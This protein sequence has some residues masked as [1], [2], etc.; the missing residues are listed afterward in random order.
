MN[1]S[2]DDWRI[3]SALLDEALEVPATDRTAWFARRDDIPEHLLAT[4]RSMVDPEA[5]S[6]VLPELPAYSPSELG[7]LESHETPVLRQGESVGP[8]RL[9]REI[10]QG[11]MGTVWLAER[12]DE[13]L[14]REVALKLPHSTLT[15]PHLAERF[16]RERDILAALV[17]PNIARLYDAGITDQGQP[18]L[19]LEYVDGQSLTDYCSAS[20]RNISARIEL[21]LQVLLAVQYAH[22]RLVVHRDLKPSNVLVTVEG[23]IRLLDFGIAKLLVDGQAHETE[24]TEVGGRA[25]TPQYAAPEQIL[26]LP[27]TTAVDVYA[28]GVM[29]YELLTGVLPYR[30]KRDSRGALEDAIVETEVLPPSRAIAPEQPHAADRKVLRGDLDT[31]VLKALKKEPT[32]RYATSAAFADDL[33][34]YLDGE[35]VLARP[36]STLYR[37]RKFLVRNRWAA[38]AV[39]LVMVALSAGLGVALW[40]AKI[41]RQESETAGAVKEFMQGIFLANSAQQGDPIKA[42]QTTA[43]DLLDIGAGKLDTALDKAPE[44]KLEMLQMFGELYSQLQLSER[45][46]EFMEK[47]VALSKVVHGPVSGELV[48]AQLQLAV[49]LRDVSPD[50]PQ[51]GKVLDVA[52]A[53]L[54]QRHETQ[55]ERR[56]IHS[57]LAADY[58]ADRDFPRA[59]DYARRAAALMRQTPDSGDFAIVLAKD[60]RI[61]LQAGNCDDA[62]TAAAEAITVAKKQEGTR[63]AGDGSNT[64]YGALHEALGLADRCLGDV[65]AGATHLQQ[66]LNASRAAFGDNDT[67][68]LSIQAHLADILLVNGRGAQAATELAQASALLDKHNPQDTSRLYLNALAALGKAQVRAGQFEPALANLTKVVSIRAGVDASVAVAEVLR[69]QARALVALHRVKEAKQ[70]LEQAVTMRAKSGLQSTK[71]D[72]EEAELRR[73]IG[74]N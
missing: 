50:H 20:Q 66:A 2:Q 71:L 73:E 30:P 60:A 45:A 13:A 51:I 54:D 58:Y 49:A 12:R 63:K 32:A 16:K 56:S 25:L 70:S 57:A 18:Y 3:L 36:D 24:L 74:S 44:A 35:P 23:H 38:A 59:V 43:R 26:G 41:A 68:T 61:E 69:D 15:K 5:K 14:K 47:K 22:S 8:Y 33:Q 64:V 62:R 39:C 1:F 52:D 11:G 4:A 65:P 48:E 31:I 19:A 28:L 21:F 37:W 40:Q 27:I 9:L 46:L 55:G 10:G 72:Q 34:R 29:L 42:R 53:I 6:F 17:H 67:E 7:E